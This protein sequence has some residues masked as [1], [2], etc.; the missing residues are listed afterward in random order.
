M[1]CTSQ[2]STSTSV[3]Y[4]YLSPILTKPLISSRFYINFTHIPSNILLK[5]SAV[6]IYKL[7]SVL[8]ALFATS[9]LTYAILIHGDPRNNDIP[10]FSMLY[11]IHSFL[12]FFSSLK[13]TKHNRHLNVTCKRRGMC[14]FQ[15]S[16]TYI[17]SFRI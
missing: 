1:L 10:L 8:S 5:H 11:S 2:I 16:S 3:S 6:P 14:P 7:N 12:L 17:L 15:L 9:Y 13:K 4:F